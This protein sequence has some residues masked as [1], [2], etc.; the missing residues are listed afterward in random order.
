MMNRV[1]FK[2]VSA[3]LVKEFNEVKV[4]NFEELEIKVRELSLR[5]S[6]IKKAP[7]IHELTPVIDTNLCGRTLNIISTHLRRSYRDPWP[8]LLQLSEMSERGLLKWKGAG[9]KTV[10]EI[11]HVLSLAGLS[12]KTLQRTR[13]A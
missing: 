11:N 2:E 5:I 12:L 3:A 9:K 7:V 10:Q 4:E 6:E 1:H 8:T 13:Q